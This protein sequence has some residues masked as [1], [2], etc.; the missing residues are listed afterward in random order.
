MDMGRKMN[1]FNLVSL[2]RKMLYSV[3]K[4]IPQMRR[5][6]EEVWVRLECLHIE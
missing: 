2:L 4:Y 3:G 1:E 5:A 6:S